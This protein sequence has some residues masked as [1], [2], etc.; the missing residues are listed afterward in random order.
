MAHG[1]T[2]LAVLLILPVCLATAH[3]PNASPIGYAM[4]YWHWPVLL[5]LPRQPLATLAW[6]AAPSP[7]YLTYTTVN[8]VFLSPRA[9][10]MACSKTVRMRWCWHVCVLVIALVTVLQLALVQFYAP[11]AWI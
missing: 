10:C 11:G 2:R 7:S 9:L 5:R 8:A 3:T 4:Q 6:A 1:Y